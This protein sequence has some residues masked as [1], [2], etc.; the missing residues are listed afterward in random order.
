MGPTTRSTTTTPPRG[1]ASGVLWVVVA[2][3]VIA[4]VA[5]VRLSKPAAAPA[6][7]LR[8]YPSYAAGVI[9]PKI[10]VYAAPASNSRVVATLAQRN[11][12]GAPQTF[13]VKGRA[14][15]ASNGW[16]YQVMLPVRPNGSK[17]WVRASDVKVVGLHYALVVHLRSFHI[18]LLTDGRRTSVFRIGV[19]TQN[20]PTPSG[21]YYVK[22]LI[23]PPNPN[24]IYGHYVLGLSGF[25][26]VLKNWPDGG[27]IGIHGTNDLRSIG[28]RVSHGCIRMSNADIERLARTLPLGTPVTVRSD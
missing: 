9:V 22:E 16:W 13:L 23:Q 15:D 27:V 11:E 1:S 17:G 20:T 2:G 26:N 21:E 19:G 28:R 7:D 5:F 4:V 14:K 3:L 12:N 8:G 25:S 24:T 18:D 10:A 6:T